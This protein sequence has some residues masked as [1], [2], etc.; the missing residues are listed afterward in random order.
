MYDN[1]EIDDAD[2]LSKK[3]VPASEMDK[4]MNMMENVL[5]ENKNTQDYEVP[6]SNFN[7]FTSCYAL[8]EDDGSNN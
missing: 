7:G 2:V 6:K 5:E 3:P 4:M 1:F 8:S